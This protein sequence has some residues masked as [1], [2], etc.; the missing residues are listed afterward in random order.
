[1]PEK[2]RVSP[3]TA[4]QLSTGGRQ[5]ALDPEEVDE[6]LDDEVELL[7]DEV[8]LLDEESDDLDVEEEDDE[9]EDAAGT[10]PLP[11]DRLSV[12]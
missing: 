7:D 9:S 1:M 6:L 2:V 4:S 5:A 10:E 11:E 3:A 8:E 12:R